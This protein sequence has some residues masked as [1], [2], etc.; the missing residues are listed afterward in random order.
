M[1]ARDRQIKQDFLKD[2]IVDKGYN[3]G[4]FA[5]FLLEQRGKIMQMCKCDRKRD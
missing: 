4:D 5:Q 2:Q 3:T 1:Y